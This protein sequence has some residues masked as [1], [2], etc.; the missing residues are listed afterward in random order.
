MADEPD[1]DGRT[2][3]PPARVERA[4][5][6]A[7]RQQRDAQDVA[8]HRDRRRRGPRR[9]HQ[10][11]EPPRQACHAP[12]RATALARPMRFGFQMNVDSSTA[13]PDTARSRPAT[14]PA[15]GPPIEPRQPPHDAD[16]GDPRQGDDARPPRAASRRRSGTPPGRAGSST[17]R[18][19]GRRRSTS[20]ARAAGRRRPGRTR[21]GR[22]CR[23]PGR[24]PTCR[25]PRGRAGAAAAG[26]RRSSAD[27]ATHGSNRAAR[28]EASRL[29]AVIRGRRPGRA[30]WSAANAAGGSGASGRSGD[31]GPR[32]VQVD[33]VV[34]LV[35]ARA[36]R[37]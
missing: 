17:R 10:R 12:A 35:H 2:D 30:R 3:P 16:R 19:G 37:G 11:G 4:A 15:H 32:A 26:E 5:G 23:G 20:A 1:P 29:G 13:A 25:V 14:S 9:S 7:T 27:A 33:R 21:A 18:R 24:R 6:R 34:A 31:E 8:L 28:R 36:S 22:A